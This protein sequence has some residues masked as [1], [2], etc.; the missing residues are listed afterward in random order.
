MLFGGHAD[1]LTGQF[2]FGAY[3]SF[4]TPVRIDADLNPAKL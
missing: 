4:T 1:V 2:G 3:S